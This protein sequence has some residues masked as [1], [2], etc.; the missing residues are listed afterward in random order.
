MHP[1]N[2]PQTPQTDERNFP[3]WEPKA[4]PG[5]S[6][7]GYPKMLTRQFTKDDRE[8]WREQH[9]RFDSVRGEYWEER[10]PKVGDDV[11]VV[12]TI[13]LVDAGYANVI[14]EAVIAAN[15]DE[16][17]AIFE[18]IGERAPV[19]PAAAVSIPLAA[20]RRA[21]SDLEAENA[22]LRRALA[23]KPVKFP[24]RRKGK[25]RKAAAKRLT[26]DEMAAGDAATR[27]D[28]AED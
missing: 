13:E 11:P 5:R 16:E 14:G 27:D 21:T 9:K 25:R 23:A 26:L 22:A 7:H 4:A 10:C 2:I 1:A 8:P 18:M 3:R 17:Q 6:G 19:P 12:A 24:T 28:T 20:P 15:E